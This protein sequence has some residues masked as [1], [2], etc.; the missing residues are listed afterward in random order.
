MAEAATFKE[1]AAQTWGMAKETGK[2]AWQKTKEGT[3]KAWDKTKKTYGAT[4]TDWKASYNIGFNSGVNDYEHVA[5]RFGSKFMATVG[6]RNGLRE[7][8]RNAKYLKKI[9]KEK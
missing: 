3:K 6:Y 9:S 8:H 1:K 2:E 7:A 5:S 4:K